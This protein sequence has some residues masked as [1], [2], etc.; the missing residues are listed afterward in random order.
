MIRSSRAWTSWVLTTKVAE[1]SKGHTT[2][3][4]Q[5]KRRFEVLDRA[6]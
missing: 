1:L 4:A 6:A 3:K 2:G 5:I